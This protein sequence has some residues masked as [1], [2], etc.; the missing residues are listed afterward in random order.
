MKTMNKVIDKKESEKV[1]IYT[2]EGIS[3][4]EKVNIEVKETGNLN[5]KK[6][7]AIFHG[8][9]MAYKG[10][11]FLTEYLDEYKLFYFNAP[12]RGLSSEVFNISSNTYAKLYTSVLEHLFI[13]GKI[14]SL[15]LIGYSMGGFNAL[16]IA[17]ENNLQIEKI[18]ILNS[19][20]ELKDTD[21]TTQAGL[22]TTPETYKLSNIFPIGFG[23]Q[24]TQSYKDHV[25]Q[26]FP[27]LNKVPAKAA[28]SD[29]FTVATIKLNS[30]LNKLNIPTLFI[31]VKEDLIVPFETTLASKE[32]MPNSKLV[33]FE[34][35][36]HLDVFKCSD[37]DTGLSDQY[38]AAIQE[39]L[40]M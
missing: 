27:I 18:I 3:E 26:M 22:K 37:L 14:D 11:E 24:T 29:L 21:I 19:A 16:Q 13:E 4:N 20:G 34:G 1:I 32:K 23:S 30:V 35:A 36:G 15:I 5:S 33:T 8:A 25:I 38:G 28:V 7:I 17:L 6:S 31:A 39:F 2:V 10:M 40:S 12:G 9:S